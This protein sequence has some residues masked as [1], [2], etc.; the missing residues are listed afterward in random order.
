[1]RSYRIYLASLFLILLFP[2]CAIGQKYSIPQKTFEIYKEAA[3]IGDVNVYLDC[4]TK[5]SRQMLQGQLPQKEV[6][7]QE[8]NYLMGKEYKVDIKDDIAILYF[9]KNTEYEPPYLFLKENNEWKIDLKA[10]EERIFFD[11][12]KK[13]YIVGQKYLIPSKEEKP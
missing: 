2:F 13:W 6:L 7:I 11:K 4:I 5:A 8:Y 10:M 1:M 9:K 12:D 3:L